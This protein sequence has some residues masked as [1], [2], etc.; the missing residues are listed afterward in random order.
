M[1]ENKQ[2]ASEWSHTLYVAM[3]IIA[4]YLGALVAMA[5]FIDSRESIFAFVVSPSLFF[6]LVLF[7]PM[8]FG[9]YAMTEY[10][11][12]LDFSAGPTPFSRTFF[13]I[14]GTL[15]GLLLFP[16]PFFVLC[17]LIFGYIY[18]AFPH[19]LKSRS[20]PGADLAEDS[21]MRP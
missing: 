6:Y 15:L 1:L 11:N 5:P 7:L 13:P 4:P 14:V 12:D 3:A 8:L 17:G 2:P 9:I 10:F 16:H 20:I 19:K 21:S 18:G